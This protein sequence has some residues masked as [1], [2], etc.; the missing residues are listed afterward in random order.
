MAIISRGILGGFRGKVANVVGTSWKGR[1]VM[2]SLP[3]SVANPRSTGQ[4]A[5]R[6][7]F[8]FCTTIASGLLSGW[9]RPLWNPFSGD[10]SGYN[11]FVSVNTPPLTG[12]PI[13][14]I[15]ALQL[16]VGSLAPI[17]ASNATANIVA[18]DPELHVLWDTGLVG[19][20]LATDRVYVAVIESNTGEILG[21]SSGTSVIGDGQ[22]LFNLKKELVLA[23]HIRIFFA[24]KRANS[25]AVSNSTSFDKAILS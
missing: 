5:Q 11:K 19:N 4:V 24:V 13:T 17:D 25:S 1:A 3:L 2:K 16:S 7:K 6:T 23:Q 8:S 21:V 9:I 22:V 10:I 14:D 15:P 20:Q 12:N 18:G